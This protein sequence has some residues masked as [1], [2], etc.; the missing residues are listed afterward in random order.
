M[1]RR[2][3]KQLK[4]ELNAGHRAL[5]TSLSAFQPARA[6]QE[7]LDMTHWTML[8]ALGSHKRCRSLLLENAGQASEGQTVVARHLPSL[9]TCAPY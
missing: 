1:C 5:K 9:Q 8:D 3:A 2:L 6:R 4:I 7:A